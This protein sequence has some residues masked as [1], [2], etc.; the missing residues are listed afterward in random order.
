MSGLTKGRAFFCAIINAMDD[1]KI[2]ISVR[3]LVEFLYRE[4]DIDNRTGGSSEQTMQEGSRMHRKLQKEAGEQYASEVPL[5]LEMEDLVLEGRADGIYYGRI[6]ESYGMGEGTF[7]TVDEIKTT[8]RKIGR[9]KRP[10]TVHLAQ[11]RCYAY[12]LAKN[13]DLARVNVRMTYCN[14]ES[15]QVR[16]FFEEWKIEDLEEW[17]QRLLHRY[18]RWLRF[19]ID[20]H[21]KRTTS[22]QSLEFP[23]PYR[24]GQKKLAAGVYW[25]IENK[26]N[27]YLEAPTGTGKTITTLFPAI[28]AMGEGKTQRIFYLTAK[29][30]LGAAA[31]GTID[32]LREHGLKAK[33]TQ[34]TAKEKICVMERPQCDPDHCMRAKGHYD[35]VNDAIYDLLQ[36][37]DAFDR[38][39]IRK[40]AFE[41]NVCPFELSLDMTLF[42]DII[43]ADYN[44]VFD[45]HAYL[46]RFFGDGAGRTSEEPVFL[47]D[48]AHNLVDRGRNMYSAVL[49]RQDLLKAR[50]LLGELY[51]T[52][53]NPIVKCNSAMRRLES[54]YDNMENGL[55][56]IQDTALLP[57][58][59][60]L[61]GSVQ[62]LQDVLSGILQHERIARQSGA[63]FKDPFYREKEAVREDLLN[64]YYNICHFSLIVQKRDDHY[65]TYAKKEPD[66]TF[67]VHLFCVDPS[68]NLRECM[69]RG[70]S[71]I[72]FS[73]TL[74]PITY[75]KP[76]L[77]G[78]KDD[79]EMYAQSV[80]DPEKQ[81]IYAVSDVTS[82]YSM[83][84]AQQ[85]ARIAACIRS[86]TGQRHGNYMI[87]FPSYDFLQKEAAYFMQLAGLSPDQVEVIR[88]AEEKVKNP[89]DEQLSLF[90]VAEEER[91]ELP[92]EQDLVL[93]R[94]EL[95]EDLDTVLETG[96]TGTENL[97]L[98]LQTQHM[99]EQERET[100]LSRFEEGRDDETLIGFCV[101]GGLFSE[102]IDLRRDS[103]IGAGIV[104][105]GI[106]QVGAERELLRYYFDR[107]GR[108]GYDFAY[109]YPGMNKVLQAA[110]RVIRTQEDV[111]IVVLM[112][113]RFLT[114]NYQRLFPREWKDVHACSSREIA[115]FVE[116]FW[117]EWL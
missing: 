94:V 84:S 78:T 47:V 9:I 65:T 61:T 2:T 59:D 95:P 99:S 110:G 116:R 83:R 58:I 64:F 108:N 12:M 4:G 17:M 92:K 104:G 10:K 5:V 85:Y 49:V 106:P 75:Y 44:Y 11:A 89:V 13:Q 74:L 42:C 86:F 41:H 6:P 97:H 21:A 54:L 79:Y 63:L 35:R 113:D 33:S 88:L 81:G 70:R 91:K 25:S 32:L 23:Y 16:Y 87:F 62:E 36:R 24:K 38:D 98:L 107:H 109:T 51:P 80:F 76:L 37:V 68:K 29:T 8:Y 7:W 112:D 18:D 34:L 55:T 46:R 15:E 93:P 43:I 105:T 115:G 1:W 53:V 39:S 52:L 77:G 45:P 111:G 14:L 114:K 3:T 26:K 22:I 100:F 90:P 19:H 66:G 30:V 40:T 20:W 67:S 71:T 82:R 57:D 73:A 72:L 28:K 103:L 50:E 117:G 27:L 56:R 31:A 101:L 48:E 96:L 60:E 69:N 102:G